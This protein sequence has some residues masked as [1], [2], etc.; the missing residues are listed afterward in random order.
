MEDTE[1]IKEQ[2]DLVLVFMVVVAPNGVKSL[3]PIQCQRQDY[4]N[5]VNYYR[6]MQKAG[7]KYKK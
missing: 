5:G 6:E 3:I 7:R 2:Q 1:L 4:I